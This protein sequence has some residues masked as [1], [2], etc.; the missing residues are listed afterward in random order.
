MYRSDEELPSGLE[1]LDRVPKLSSGLMKEPR[2][3]V[4][5]LNTNR[6]QDTLECLTS[7]KKGTYENF[8]VVLLDN[9]SSDG[10]VEAV[11][12]AFP[13]V[14]IIH[15]QENRGYAGNN[16]IGVQAALELEADWVF[17]L[18]EDTIVA[19]DCLNRLMCVAESDPK[20]GIVGP[21]VYHHSEPTVI[22]TAGG[23]LGRSWESKHY[24]QDEE[25]CGQYR[26]PRDV[27]WISGCG[28]VVRRDVIEEV[29]AIDE[30]FFY[31]WEE[32]EW[33]LRARRA[34]WRIL[35]VPQAKIW[36]KG[37]QRNHRPQPTV[38]YYNT[39]NR[40]LTLSKMD[41]PL[42]VWTGVWLQLVRTW[43][44]WTIRR[45]WRHM[46]D[47]RTAMVLGAYDF[48]RG[49]LGGPVEL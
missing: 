38:T 27:E 11:N 5:I 47:H 15:L 28:I 18:N 20:I 39:R 30:R 31:Y 3:V 45:R 49:R 46:R 16:N 2:V 35:N 23:W 48:L 10:T 44:S 43:A 8:Q 24:G 37:V 42:K 7:L 19:P 22:Q 14:K 25:D 26:E 13:W 41:A 12:K 29:G 40:L 21:L 1:H 17:V 34:A 33:C 36:H 4:V 6:R 9:A 32:T